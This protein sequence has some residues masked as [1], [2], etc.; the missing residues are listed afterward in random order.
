M[1][2]RK[3]SLC[4][5]IAAVF[6]I[7]S[8]YTSVW[9]ALTPNTS[10]TVTIE[11]VKSDG[12]IGSL[13]LST[14]GTTDN[15]GKLSFTMSSVPSNDTCNFLVT[16]ITDGSGAT[17]RK[18]IAPC[19]DV[20]STLPLGISPLTTKQTTAL[21]DAFAA[22]GTD[23]SILAVF[24]SVVVRS[25]GVTDTEL[26][27]IANIINSGIN[28]TGGFAD[29]LTSNGV[30]AS[31]LAAYRSAIVANL[32]NASSG[33]SKIMKDAVDDGIASATAERQKR[34]EA[35]AKLMS[36]LVDAA[37]TAGFSPDL[38]LEAFNAMGS[39]VI[40]LFQTAVANG[41]INAIVGKSIDSSVGGGVDK[42]RADKE[43]KNYQDA[44]TTLGASGAELTQFTTAAS[45]LSD[46][47]RSAFQT[48]EEVFDDN[49]DVGKINTAQGAME[50]TMN[51]A[52][53]TFTTAIAAS[54]T[55]LGTLVT[56]LNGVLG[57]GA[58]SNT[59]FQTYAKDGSTQ[60]NWPITMVIVA[61]WI[62]DAVIANG[63]NINTTIAYTRDTVALPGAINWIGNCSDN[64]ST[65][66]G[67][68]T[69]AGGGWTVERTN[70]T[71][72]AMN[73][74]ASYAALFGIQEDIM[75][76]DFTRYNAD[77]AANGDM[78][79]MQTMEKAYSDALGTIAGNISGTN[80][81]STAITAAQK[82]A[83]VRLLK[84]PQ[85]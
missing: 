38:V 11:K 63:N 12:T 10:Y 67:T 81:N 22:A 23:D 77:T 61:N 76:R 36:V 21:L 43:I 72:A 25:T 74:P 56:A 46:S 45:A 19:P 50:T 30:S 54:N 33:Y 58:V 83:I 65:D 2:N 6:F 18:G 62:N 60:V 9:A 48:S 40:P 24:G 34:G 53:N 31:E 4:G 7:L 8:I 20:D 15:N 26:K 1:K 49:E 80:P 82:K 68:C 35:A 78:S 14:A 70:F 57:A 66:P 37:D 28:G 69:G 84:S 39:V 85:F 75:I 5:M 52:F 29:Y 51:N 47:M 13:G 41:D 64:S 3:I 73:I 55:S 17:V 27:K 32:A 79:A 71:G 44:L 16:T 42:L 59:D